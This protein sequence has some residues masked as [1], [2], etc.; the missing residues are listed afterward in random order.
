MKF[1]SHFYSKTFTN[2]NKTSLDYKTDLKP[3]TKILFFV[4]DSSD[5]EAWSGVVSTHRFSQAMSDM[6][7][8]LGYYW[9]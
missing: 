5:K 9:R 4:A 1:N 6:N 2:I 3:G 7:G 8:T